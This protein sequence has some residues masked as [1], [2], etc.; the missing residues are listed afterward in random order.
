M[1]N[2]PEQILKKMYTSV[3]RNKFDRTTSFPITTSLS[4]TH[5]VP[6]FVKPLTG[7]TTVNLELDQYLLTESTPTPI[8]EGMRVDTR[9]FFCAQRH[10][11]RGLYGD[12]IDEAIDIEQIPLPRVPLNSAYTMVDID[13]TGGAAIFRG[14]LLNRLG[15][16]A[17][18]SINKAQRPLNVRHLVLGDADR[19]DTVDLNAAPSYANWAVVAAYF[20]ICSRY[21]ANKFED[22]VPLGSSVSASLDG[23]WNLQ[24]LEGQTLSTFYS[25]AEFSR[26]VNNLRGVLNTG[27]SLNEAQEMPSLDYIAAGSSFD[28]SDG[29][30]YFGPVKLT[31][32]WF[33]ADNPYEEFSTDSITPLISSLESV[34]SN[35]GL[36]PTRFDSHYQT[37]F[38][39]PSDIDGLLEE[40]V[41]PDIRSYRLAQSKF[42]S[43]LRAILR[44]RTTRSWMNA[45]YGTKLKMTDHPIFVGGDS[46]LVNFQNIVASAPGTQTTDTGI[47]EIRLGDSGGRG[48]GGTQ[49]AFDEK[50][51]RNLK[52]ISFTTQEPGYLIGI[53][54]CTPAVSY[55]DAS[56]NFHEY[57]TLADFPL[58]ARSGKLFQSLRLKNFAFTGTSA[59]EYEVGQQP[60]GFDYMT[61]YGRVS[62]LYGSKLKESYVFKR[63]FDLYGI[64]VSSNTAVLNYLRSV[65]VEPSTFDNNFN[66][67]GINARQN[68]TLK[69][70]C[71]LSVVLPLSDQV[72][73]YNA[74]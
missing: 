72:T 67:A 71:N 2:S 42:S 30:R 23:G 58:P 53:V 28:F 39:K 27:L 45:Q 61:E 5:A 7:N 57:D 1:K 13:S 69:T 43:R 32:S 8:F 17:Q 55:S 4:M 29:A 15:V 46:F 50:S 54:T 20:D 74:F 21:L 59:D 19:F 44:G 51:K 64:G 73:D 18:I 38:F 48:V 6:F 47:R 11:T 41:G 33:Q 14:S 31:D 60:Y 36:W 34:F 66:D 37:M 24:G 3:K 70:M 12:N 63:D 10:Y 56:E 62:A 16:P 35:C 26:T 65:Y 25:L 40:E 49:R 68:F 22:R 52:E 9:F